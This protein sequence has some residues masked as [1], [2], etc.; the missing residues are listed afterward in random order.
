MRQTAATSQPRAPP[1]PRHIRPCF[2]HSTL[3]P[4]TLPPPLRHKDKRECLRRI[5]SRGHRYVLFYLPFF[6][7]TK[8]LFTI[9]LQ[10]PRRR[11]V[12]NTS[13][14][15]GEMGAGDK[16]GLET[17]HEPQVCVFFLLFVITILI[18]FKDELHHE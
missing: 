2:H 15:A 12:T 10:V 5:V 8:S 3:P 6:F 17:R 1:H 11:T 9:R 18:L 13:G 16:W 4:S 7:F 14:E